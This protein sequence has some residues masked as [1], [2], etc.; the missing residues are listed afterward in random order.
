MKK[1]LFLV[2]TVILIA[3]IAAY[4]YFS[5]RGRFTTEPQYTGLARYTNGNDLISDSDP[6][7]VLRFDSAFTHIGGQKFNLYGVADTEQHLFVEALPDGKVKSLY[8]IQ[9]E[10]YLPDNSY[11]YDYDSS[12]LRV[13]LNGYEFHTDTAPGAYRPPP[14]PPR[15]TDGALVR[16]LLD[17]K[18]YE[19]PRDFLYARLVHLPDEARRK[20]LLIIFLE[21]LEL[22]GMTGTELKP[23]GANADRW[24]ALEQEHLDR[25]RSTLTVLPRTA[26]D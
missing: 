13:N 5:D 1:V 4:F 9:Y 25:I 20:E 14:I 21:N 7:V 6:D 15:G 24:P 10:A 16:Q 8:W 12:P 3:L 19:Y 11:T 2:A 17:S 26:V 23:D 18:G 22:H